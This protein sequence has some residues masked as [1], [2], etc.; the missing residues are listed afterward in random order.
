MVSQN[1]NTKTFLEG[2]GEHR[3][4]MRQMYTMWR[5]REPKY[6]CSGDKVWHC[7]AMYIHRERRTEAKTDSY[8]NDRIFQKL[9]YVYWKFGSIKVL[10]LLKLMGAY[11]VACSTRASFWL[12]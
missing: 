11:L 8:N 3:N 10:S 4:K 6:I 1:A 9:K 5:L 2:F 7:D 12:I